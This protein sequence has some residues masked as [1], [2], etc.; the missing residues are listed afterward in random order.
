M[1]NVNSLYN[2]IITNIESKL[3]ITISIKN[4]SYNDTTNP[5]KSKAEKSFNTILNGFIA[6]DKDVSVAISEAISDASEKY[7]IDKT[8]I[9]AVIRQESNFNQNAVSS[10]GASGLMQLMPNTAK[11][12]GVTN[13]F[14]I[15]QNINGGTQ[16]LKN[17]LDK[18]NGNINLALAAYNAGAG[19]VKKY[20]GVPPF[21]ET[22]NY[23]PKVLDY[24]KEYMLNQ[25]K[26]NSKK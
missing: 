3:P 25:Y 6:N 20:G 10:A 2:E 8:L 26:D 14:N 17:Q 4:N 15:S 5:D 22:Q 11:S 21:K 1:L 16:Y 12:L 19:N 23:I 7:D 18:F 9:A 13:P 24:Q